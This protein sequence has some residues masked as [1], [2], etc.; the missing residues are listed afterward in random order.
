MVFYFI[1]VFG[2]AFLFFGIIPGI[3][4]F[5]VRSRWRKFRKRIIELSLKPFVSYSETSS[6]NSGFIGEYRFFGTIEGIQGNDRI[7]VRSGNLSVAVDMENVMVYTLPSFIGIRNSDSERLD[8]MIPEEEPRILT[9]DQVFSLPE[10]TNIFIG[11]SLFYESGIG[12]FKTTPESMLLVV[13]YDGERETIIKRS[14]W[15]G[16]QRN[17]YFNQFTMASIIAGSFS[18]VLIAFALLNNPVLRLPALFSI[19][20][21]LFPIAVFLPPGVIFYF[22]YRWAWKKG[23]VLR[24]TRDLLRLPLR[25]FE[26]GKD[27]VNGDSLSDSIRVYDRVSE[28]FR[29]D[30]I[31]VSKTEEGCFS[32]Y[33]KLPT[34]ELYVEVAGLLTADEENSQRNEWKIKCGREVFTLWGRLTFRETCMRNDRVKDK[35]LFY[36]YGVYR[37]DEKDKRISNSENDPMCEL[38]VIPG[39]PDLRAERCQIR[40]RVYEWVSALFVGF[41]LLVNMF[42]ILLILHN[43]I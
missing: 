15:S 27:S 29:D 23:R 38:V 31:S 5:I 39:N 21:S 6:A 18:L 10:G 25:Y 30:T 4:A 36:A 32:R 42:F 14:I 40:A 11:G 33:S 2:V 41:G 16:R 43:Y 26:D 20:L 19:T 22:L 12:I 8:E 35:D 9:W 37:G 13:I 28:S 1:L 17:E 3:G 7:W 24:A 34:G